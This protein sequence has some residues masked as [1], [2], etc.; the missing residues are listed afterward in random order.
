MSRPSTILAAAVTAAFLC[1]QVAAADLEPSGSAPEPSA[2]V[3]VPPPATP[4]GDRSDALLTRALVA[5]PTG[6]TAGNYTSLTE[7]LGRRR[8]WT[9]PAT[10]TYLAKVMS[11]RKPDGGWGLER[12]YD[13]F[14]DGSVNPAATTYTVSLVGVGEMLLLG[15]QA[16]VVDRTTMITVL[17]RLYAIPRIPVTGGYCL[18]YSAAAADNQAGYCVHN[19]SAGAAAFLVRAQRAGLPPATWWQTNL[20][21]YEVRTYDPD[22]RS[23]RYFDSSPNWN[24][25]AHNGYSIASLQVLAPPIAAEAT[26]YWIVR[27]IADNPNDVWLHLGL[28]PFSCALAAQWL[29]EVDVEFAKPANSTFGLLVQAAAL[30]AQAAA[31]CDPPPTP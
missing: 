6:A 8:G 15:Y 17:Q 11:L 19:V 20:A 1:L 18:S 30:T 14:N 3:S 13:A 23:W 29:P 4:W 7:A 16:G 24:D 21:R 5:D 10:S 9:D 27:D 28:A 12:A 25:P 31:A 2:S 26:A 22:L